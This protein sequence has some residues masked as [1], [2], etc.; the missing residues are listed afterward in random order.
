MED[1][2]HIKNEDERKELKAEELEKVYGGESNAPAKK[3]KG[4]YSRAS[5]SG[6]NAHK[7]D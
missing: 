1:R 4:F 7:E 2:K 3:Y 6:K 5:S